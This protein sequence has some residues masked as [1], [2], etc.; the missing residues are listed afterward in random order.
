V[1]VSNDAVKTGPRGGRIPAAVARYGISRSGLY[2]YA[3]IYPGLF[4]KN[5][6]AT[7]V[8]YVIGDQIFD[9][10]PI[11]E[12]KPSPKPNKSET[13]KTKAAPAE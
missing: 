2:G 8:D 3:A 13:T 6:K 9:N 11:A 5:G 10:L 12:I 1:L 7:I 4:K